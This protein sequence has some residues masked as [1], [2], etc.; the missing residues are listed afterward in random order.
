MDQRAARTIDHGRPKAYIPLRDGRVKVFNARYS[1][2]TITDEQGRRYKPGMRSRAYYQKQEMKYRSKAANP[3]LEEE[4]TVMGSHPATLVTRHQLQ[5]VPTSQPRFTRPPT[6]GRRRRG[7]HLP[8]HQNPDHPQ[9]QQQA[10]QAFFNEAE[11]G[12]WVNNVFV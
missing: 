10:Q 5:T 9:Y 4:A 8:Q 6:N 11:Q 12:D 1:G 2:Q 3:L 7:V